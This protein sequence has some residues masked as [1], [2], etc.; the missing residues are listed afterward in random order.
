[1]S[2]GICKQVLQAQ[3]L[4][5]LN[6]ID[7]SSLKAALVYILS[8]CWFL[9][10][11][12]HLCIGRIVGLAENNPVRTR[13]YGDKQP[14][15]QISFFKLYSRLQQSKNEPSMF[16]N[17]YYLFVEMHFYLFCVIGL[18]SF[19]LNLAK[20]NYVSRV[21]HCPVITGAVSF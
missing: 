12:F 16:Y 18:Q 2:I 20:L 3:S 17:K 8:Q 11:A 15:C 19:V 13:R 9:F 14:N 6:M 21:S 4:A 7:L 1:M 5:S 10:V